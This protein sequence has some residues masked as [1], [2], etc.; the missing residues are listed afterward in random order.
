VEHLLVQRLVVLLGAHGHEYVA[1]DEL[2][3][4][5]AVRRLDG[6]D[7]VLVLQLDHHALDAPV[8]VPGLHCVVAPGLDVIAGVEVH[9]HDAVVGHAQQLLL[10]V[11]VELDDEESYTEIGQGLPGLD[12]L[13]L[14]LH[15]G[16]LLNIGMGLQ[17]PLH[18]LAR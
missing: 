5:L 6:E 9:A 3:H 13:H 17:N 10:L 7:D 8:D 4:H 2:V 12:V 18:R 1:A 15:Q 11:S 14:G 16:Q